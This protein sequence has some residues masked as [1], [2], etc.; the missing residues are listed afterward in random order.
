MDGGTWLGKGLANLDKFVDKF[1]KLR[2]ANK[3]A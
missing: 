2:E 3:K 1:D